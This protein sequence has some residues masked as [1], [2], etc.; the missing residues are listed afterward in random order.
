MGRGNLINPIL[1]IQS[2]FFPLQQILSLKLYRNIG[3]S[4][5][6]AI[7]LSECRNIGISEYRNIRILEYPNIGISEYR[8][9]YTSFSVFFT[10]KWSSLIIIRP[11]HTKPWFWNICWRLIF[12]I[13]D[14]S[15]DPPPA[16]GCPEYVSRDTYLNKISD[17]LLKMTWQNEFENDLDIFSQL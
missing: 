10:K 7:G 2:I 3:I 1:Y 14:N 17:L 13:F 5:Y 15:Y 8:K 16:S 11:R 12:N 4:E 6:R 9:S